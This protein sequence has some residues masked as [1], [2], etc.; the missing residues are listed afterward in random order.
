M[1]LAGPANHELDKA[2]HSCSIA[3]S[4]IP[5]H[6]KGGIVQPEFLIRVTKKKLSLYRMTKMR[7]NYNQAAYATNPCF[8]D[9]EETESNY[10]LLLITTVSNQKM[11]N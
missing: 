4:E 1:L 9:I 8:R 3:S 10:F 5:C 6:I 11:Q 7:K 2:S